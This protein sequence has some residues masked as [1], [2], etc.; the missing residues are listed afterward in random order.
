MKTKTGAFLA[1]MLISAIVSA[2]SQKKTNYNPGSIIKTEIDLDYRVITELPS[3]IIES[4]GLAVQNANEIWTHEDSGNTNEIYSFDTTGQLK[5]VLKITNATNVDWED[6]T[7]DSQGRF[8]ISDAGNNNNKRT[9]LVIYR[10][11][12]PDDIASGSVTAER[13]EFSY[14]DQTEFPPPKPQRNFDCEAIIWHDDS[15]FLFTKNRTNPFNGFC[16]LYKLPA[17]PGNHI[18]QLIDS[19]YIGSDTQTG[20]VTSAD[21]NR[22]S[23]ELV[24]L[25]S[26]KI[27]SFRNYPG[28][29]FFKGN[30]IDYN[31]KSLPGQVEGIAFVTPNKLYMSSEGLGIIPGKLFEIVFNI[32]GENHLKHEPPVFQVF[33]N[34]ATDYITIDTAKPDGSQILISDI[35]G[36]SLYISTLENGKAIN[37]SGLSSGF[38]I[39]SLLN[40]NAYS[41]RFWIKQ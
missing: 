3:V 38:Y 37:I 10:I 27:V 25:T 29:E 26:S 15:L 20:R 18:A 17:L 32:N 14:E 16:K 33:P 31:F 24:L 9:D 2:Q 5:R 1:I 39:L 36:Q 30:R 34:P 40:D 22:S 41:S 4:S 11:P 23:G 6:L 35:S 12:N 21:I 19:V 28:N 13:I 7:V 8:Y